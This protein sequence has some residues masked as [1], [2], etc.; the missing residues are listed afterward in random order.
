[1][2]EHVEHGGPSS[3]AWLCLCSSGASA[4][5]PLLEHAEH[6][7]MLCSSM[8]V[9]NTTQIRG[10]LS[11]IAK[12]QMGMIAPPAGPNDSFDRTLL[13]LDNSRLANW[14]GVSSSVCQDHSSLQEEEGDKRVLR[15]VRESMVYSCARR[16]PIPTRSGLTKKE[17]RLLCRI[18]VWEQLI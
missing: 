10:G 7:S 1:M 18:P 16:Y 4:V 3:R 2:L 9:H 13:M 14:R 12:K 6:K 5:V 8:L 15:V 11:Y 17:K